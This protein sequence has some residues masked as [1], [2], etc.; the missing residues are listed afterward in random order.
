MLVLAFTAF[1]A[2][3]ASPP[4]D[5]CTDA[6][7]IAA[8]I[9]DSA[10]AL[11]PVIDAAD[12]FDLVTCSGSSDTGPPAL[13]FAALEKLEYAPVL[14]IK[15]AAKRLGVRYTPPRSKANAEMYQRVSDLP[16]KLAK[17]LHGTY[18]PSRAPAAASGGFPNIPDHYVMSLFLQHSSSKKG[19][20]DITEEG[21]DDYVGEVGETFSG[22]ATEV[23]KDASR[24]ADFFEWTHPQAHAQ[25]ANNALGTLVHPEAAQQAFLQWERQA[26]GRV[27]SSCAANHTR[28]ALYWMGY[29]LHGVQDLAFHNGISNA[30]HAWRDYGDA[31]SENGVDTKYRFGDKEYLATKATSYLLRLIRRQLVNDHLEACWNGMRT[32]QGALLTGADKK[33]IQ[34]AHKPDISK[35]ELAKY[36]ALATA[37]DARAASPPNAHLFVHPRWLQGSA[38]EFDLGVLQAI[39]DRIFTP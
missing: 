7:K 23:L 29:S 19:H 3:A 39:V 25:T 1:F 17:D 11:R 2:T 37:L 12:V 38:G 35:S 26:V 34:P 36:R 28:D 13:F 30:E 10:G 8:R 5:P 32:F 9:V 14:D 27:A 33:A 20:Y 16:P 18:K 6:G 4:A 22:R 31:Q 21:I 24:D 15:A